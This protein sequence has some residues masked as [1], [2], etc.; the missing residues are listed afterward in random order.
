MWNAWDK[1]I[2]ENFISFIQQIENDYNAR[3]TDVNDDVSR[4]QTSKMFEQ[5]INWF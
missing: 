1:E 5:K 4:K 2:D 3:L